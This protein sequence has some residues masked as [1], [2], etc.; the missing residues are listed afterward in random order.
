VA[1]KGDVAEWSNSGK[2][3][4][5]FIACTSGEEERRNVVLLN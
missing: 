3:K 4:P 1:G 2:Y 5:I